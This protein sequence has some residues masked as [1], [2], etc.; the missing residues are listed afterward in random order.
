MPFNKG[1]LQKLKNKKITFSKSNIYIY[2]RK[3]KVQNII[4][5]IE[6]KPA[7]E[8]LTKAFNYITENGRMSLKDR[9]IFTKEFLDILV[10]NKIILPEIRDLILSS[11]VKKIKSSYPKIKNKYHMSDEELRNKLEENKNECANI[12]RQNIFPKLKEIS[13]LYKN[14]DDF[15]FNTYHIFGFIYSD[16]V[17]TATELIRNLSTL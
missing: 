13:K 8:I 15:I 2:I 14:P 5:N 11:D 4:K 3:K 7:R 6:N 10:S 9:A 1:N 12:I 17:D 16:G